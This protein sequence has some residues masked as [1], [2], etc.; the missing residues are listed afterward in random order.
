MEWWQYETWQ[1][2]FSVSDGEGVERRTVQDKRQVGGIRKLARI[3]GQ[4]LKMLT[5]YQ[6]VMAD[7]NDGRYFSYIYF[8]PTAEFVIM[9]MKKNYRP[10]LTLPTWMWECTFCCPVSEIRQWGS[11]WQSSM[12]AFVCILILINFKWVWAQLL[13]ELWKESLLLK[14][15]E[16]LKCQPMGTAVST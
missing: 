6:F 11:Q 3:A 2:S 9:E 5:C 4:L 1:I 10:N 12:G 16:S 13:N 7:F 8:L 15:L 14:N